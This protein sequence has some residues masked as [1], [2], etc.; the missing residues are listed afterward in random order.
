MS[1]L[2]A[3]AL[4]AAGQAL[5]TGAMGGAEGRGHETPLSLARALEMAQAQNPQ[6]LVLRAR[7]AGAEGR[8]L[9]TRQGILPSI[10]FDATYLRGEFGLLENVPTIEPGVPPGIGWRDVNPVEGNAVG[11]QVVQPLV[12]FGAW[13]ARRQAGRQED[14]AR[15]SVQRAEDEVTVATVA[16]YYGI[17]SAQRQVTAERRGL[18]AARRGLARAK[19]ALEEGLVSPLDVLQART[20]VAD[21]RA[22]VAVAESRVTLA[23][24]RLRLVLGLE[25]TPSWVLTDEVPRPPAT[26]PAPATVSPVEQRSDVR[27]AEE[28][29][30]AAEAGVR[31]AR[32]AYLPEISLVG[33]YQRTDL[34]RPLD[35]DETDWVV[36]IRLG[37]SV[38]S[39]FGQ[40][41]R[42]DEAQAV[43]RQANAEWRAL[44]QQG[45]AQIRD[46]YAE[47]HA[48]R[49][50]W[51][52][53]SRG[54]ADAEAALALVESRY[55][56]GLDDMTTLLQAQA[57]ALGA[58]TREIVARYNAVL[59]AQ[60]YRLATDA[61][62]A[63]RW[64]P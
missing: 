17:R 62:E 18:R 37:W 15:L 6:L 61:V 22:R 31:R 26:L 49:I 20:R 40:A 10:S 48:Q 12:N 16:A 25:E 5:A 27:A 56:E 32:A 9:S 59:A 13:E 64:R 2:T 23:E 19:G 33:R 29:V 55:A 39:G 63:G 21:M 58:W 42:L 53:A 60:R 51:Q 35:L 28:I 44:R 41:G 36:G 3:F 57:E 14:A 50:G 7:Q 11:V 54:V 24:S 43:E 47:W 52:S 30:R 45:Q 8:L 34:G 46:N 38:F 1:M 4:C